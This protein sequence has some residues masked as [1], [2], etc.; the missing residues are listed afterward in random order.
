MC[1][2]NLDCR[3]LTYKELLEI[4]NNSFLFMEIWNKTRVLKEGR[5]PDYFLKDLVGEVPDINIATG[6]K[7]KFRCEKHGVYEQ[8]VGNRLH[9][10][11]CFMC[12]KEKAVKLANLAKLEKLKSKYSFSERLANC[13]DRDKVESGDISTN[14]IARFY[15]KIHGIYYKKPYEALHASNS[16]PK[17]QSIRLGKIVKEKALSRR[18]VSQSRLEIWK[19]SPCY[20]DIV[21]GKISS[22][23]K[24]SFV[25]NTHGEYTSTIYTKGCPICGKLRS[26]EK[27]KNIRRAKNPFPQWFIDDLEGSPDKDLI[28]NCNKNIDDKAFFLCKEHGM[29]YQKIGDHLYK[30]AGCPT[31]AAQLKNNTSLI[32]RM[33]IENYRNIKIIQSCRTEI[34][35]SVNGRFMELDNYIP[36]FRIGVE[37]NGF[38]YHSNEV[39][40]DSHYYNAIGGKQNYHLMKSNLCKD[41][42]IVLIHLFE[43]DTKYRYSTCLNHI[44]NVLKLQ[45]AELEQTHIKLSDCSI[46]EDSLNFRDFTL[47][48]LKGSKFKTITCNGELVA[49]ISYNEGD[50]ITVR[51]IALNSKYSLDMNPLLVLLSEFDKDI[52]IEYEYHLYNGDCLKGL[53]F[54]LLEITPPRRINVD[55]LSIKRT[56]EE[57]S[58]HIY[59]C[60]VAKW[61]KRI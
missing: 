33:L 14:E 55:I 51:N 40:N 45:G 11:P 4:S 37:Y 44:N 38:Y 29:Y 1:T 26:L 34:K 48:R 31:C 39:M 36:E 50:I 56:K 18:Q 20:E 43:D 25:C 19:T 17:C 60:G 3:I 21:R 15:C 28:L 7:L 9:G 5:W 46:V 24:V 8:T 12:S 16:C 30:G 53:G 52:C 22:S 54:E 41:K 35:S 27:R 59:D 47:S 61:I 6:T 13:L 42:D 32:E 58:Y 2:I 10:Y 57:S 49:S 23:D